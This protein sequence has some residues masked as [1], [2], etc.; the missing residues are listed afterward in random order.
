MF[1][2][3]TLSA[4]VQMS[5]GR[6]E[7]QIYDFLKTRSQHYHCQPSHKRK[8]DYKCLVGMIKEQKEIQ[9]NRP[10]VLIGPPLVILLTEHG[11]YED[12]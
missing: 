12:L 7:V 1:C 9:Y 8:K 3:I 10:Q 5:Q 4:H 11:I 2:P 6:N